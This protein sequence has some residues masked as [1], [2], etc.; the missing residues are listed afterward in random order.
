M[1][2]ATCSNDAIR[3]K[4]KF[5]STLSLRR[6]TKHGV[7]RGGIRIF[8]STLSLRRATGTALHSNLFQMDFYPRSPCGERL[9]Y[10]K[11]DVKTCD[12][13]LSTL[14]LRRATTAFLLL[15]WG[16]PISIHALLAESDPNLLI[17]LKKQ[18]YFYPRSPCGERQCQQSRGSCIRTISI[19]ALLAESDSVPGFCRSRLLI[20][21]HAL[22][23]ESDTEWSTLP[24]DNKKFLSTLSLRRA[25][26]FNTLQ[27]IVDGYFYPRSPC[28]E[29]RY[30]TTP[31]YDPYDNFYPR[32]P[33]GERPLGGVK[34]GSNITVFLSTLSL[35]RATS[36]D[37]VEIDDFKIS[38]HAL[39]A[40]SDN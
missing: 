9:N 35:R 30:T 1:R 11:I 40:E 21:I 19:H 4:T 13:F 38:I 10:K 32:S 17:E 16:L 12:T 24:E 2:R 29:R 3:L 20:S 28:G 31:E 6:A 25:T 18:R 39:L 7:C 36:A 26:I 33:C 27:I 22:L 8:L 34:I 23:A 15:S 14:S 5:L 37:F